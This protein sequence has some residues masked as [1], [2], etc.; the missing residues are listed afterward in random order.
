MQ[1][2]IL[3]SFLETREF[4]CNRH[5]KF[6]LDVL[7]GTK[8]EELSCPLCEK[9]AEKLLRK[10]ELQLRRV[11]A[12]KKMGIYEEHFDAS[13]DNYEAVNEKAAEYL[14]CIKDFAFKPMRKCLL[15]Y[16]RSGTG[17]S[18]LLS[19]LVKLL[20]GEY[21]T[22]EWLS[23]RI[24]ASYSPKARY[25]EEDIMLKMCTLPFLAIDEID[26][27]ADTEAKKNLLLMIARERHDRMRPLALA[28]NC[29][30]SWIKEFFDGSI[31]DRWIQAGTSFNF[32][33]ESYRPRL[34]KQSGG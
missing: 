5:G 14:N 17:K 28:G 27:G 6:S 31:I 16:G 11:E 7:K 8:D 29:D 15:F 9:E 4:V 25:S 18:K 30:W 1:K 10:E 26:K 12:Y 3:Q 23:I 20:G 32:D 33:W 13:L 24:R 34:E 2:N 21:I 22:Y 19:A